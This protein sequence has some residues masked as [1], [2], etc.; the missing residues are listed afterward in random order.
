MDFHEFVDKYKI[1]LN[2][3]QE[4]AVKAIDGPCL[5]LAVPGSGKTTVL[6]TRLGYM[7]F[8]KGISPENIL[9][10]TYTV[11]ATH[12]MK[13]R[14]VKIFGDT[15]PVEFRT[16]NGICSKVIDYYSKKAGREPFDLETNE[17]ERL[18]LISSLYMNATGTYPAESDTRD[19]STRITYIKNML[20]TE[21]EIR[22]MEK[23]VDYPLYDIYTGYCNKM[24]EQK[25]MDYDDQMIYAYNI[26]KGSPDTLSYFQNK[27]KYICIDEAQDTSKIQ[28]TLIRLLSGGRDNLFMV[29]DEDQ[30][31]YGFRAAY[32]AA[33]LNFKN[34]HPG[35]KILLME[36]NY[37]SNQNIV[38]AAD[39]L[40][41]NNKIRY[42][43][44]LKATRPAA[45]PVKKIQV[46]GRT[47]QYDYLLKI[48]K[49]TTEETAILYRDNESILPIVD[50]FDRN[51]VPF[52]IRNAELSFFTHRVV[53]DIIN[54]LKFTLD[55]NN[56][57]L[58]LNIYYKLGLYLPKRE[59]EELCSISRRTGVGLLK[60]IADY[61]FSNDG[62]KIR[63]LDFIRDCSIVRKKTPD[64][65][66]SYIKNIMN[67]GRYLKQCH[68]SDSKLYILQ[69]I[70]KG[71]RDIT[72][73]ISRLNEL[74]MIIRE[75]DQKS[76][77]ILSTIH[78]S[79]GLEYKNVYLIDVIDGIFPESGDITKEDFEEM[80]RI[81]YVGVTRAKDN[82]FLFRTGDTSQFIDELAVK[83]GSL[84]PSYDDYITNLFS[85]QKVVHQMFG[86]GTVTAL[87]IPFVSIKFSDKERTFGIKGLYDKN[88]LE[89]IDS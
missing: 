4:E 67:Y 73:A 50:L 5:L 68:I 29:G 25:M 12:D 69:E 57:E 70:F 39:S 8:G 34:E 51:H 2:S 13:E 44:R 78:S 41:Q 82:L 58:F 75:N 33:L 74:S 18:K 71:C 88:L 46:K 65:A 24:K 54:I 45:S 66:V 30:S 31:I 42:K 14:F 17:K 23:D 62:E 9:T 81:F 85:G 32:P 43:K 11:A 87:K 7:I 20:L 63:L 47:G 76:G 19:A 80:R 83:K 26:L 48:A 35:A 56:I 89:F 77:I 22:K 1:K 55:P 16:I 21:N 52:R 3:Q 49:E 15:V 84:L 36:E 6:V 79:K 37:R 38:E 40:I 86:K 60:V 28:H 72:A 10:L 64:S 59:A 53:T 61:K 27:Y